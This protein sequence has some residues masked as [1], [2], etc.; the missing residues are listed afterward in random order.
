MSTDTS[1]SPSVAA[2]PNT[3]A[4]HDT[5]LWLL[6]IVLALIL[7]PLIALAEFLAYWRTDIVDDQMF[8]Y[9]GWR[10]AHGATVYRDVWDNKPPGIYWIN[11][12]GMLLSGGS[13]WGVLAMCT[14]A[15]GV[16]HA[17]YFVTALSLW[18]RHAATVATVLLGFYLTHGYYTGGTNRTETFLVACELTAVAFY[19]RGWARDRWWTWYLAGAFCG[20]A[21][22]FKQVGLA[23]W[24][25]MGL[26]TLILVLARRLPVRVGVR[27]GLLLLGGVL[28]TVGLAAIYLAVQGA[29]GEAVFAAFGFN[30]AYFAA[31]LSKVDYNVVNWELLRRHVE[32][33]LLL[34]LLML[35]AATIHALLW[36]L[37]P[38]YRPPEIEGPLRAQRAVCPGYLLLF[39][40]WLAVALYGAMLSPHAFR[41]YLVPTIPPLML[42][43]GYLINVLQAEASLLQRVQQ[44]AWVLVAFVIMAYFATD[45]FRRQ[46]EVFSKVWVYRIERREPAEWEVVGE[47]IAALTE[48]TDRVQCWNYLPGAYL[49]ARRINATRFATMEKVGQVGNAARF[50]VE[51]VERTLR[52]AP[53]A[54]LVLPG[55]VYYE[56]LLG[57]DQRGS[58]SLWTLGAWVDEHYR[59]ADEVWVGPGEPVDRK[60][61]HFGTFYVFQRADRI[62]PT[63]ETDF[64]PRLEAIRA[65]FRQHTQ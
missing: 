35:V 26:H 12:V 17:A 42:L 55:E 65:Q 54:L 38:Q 47:A 49:R 64:A 22:L 5:P 32:P 45:A 9:F 61:A 30:R 48:P 20:L 10:I 60:V 41:H 11:A 57:K 1:S 50:I 25:A 62:D 34:P 29:L 27:R 58:P 21:F 28:T 18:H 16:A 46:L 15:L 3:A 31:G 4:A 59:L 23:A 7:V 8:A 53:P 51:E 40:I 44:R 36:W 37:R 24:G 43:A 52:A 6:I 56:F 33:V 2:R 13:Y 19:M 39:W 14:L 63:R